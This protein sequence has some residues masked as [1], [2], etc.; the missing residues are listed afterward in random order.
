[1]LEKNIENPQITK[2][3]IKTKNKRKITN[4]NEDSYENSDNNKNDQQAAADN[5]KTDQKEVD[6]NKTNK[7]IAENN[8]N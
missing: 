5:N 7:I 1:M 4:I 8:K 2:E 6:N 3:P